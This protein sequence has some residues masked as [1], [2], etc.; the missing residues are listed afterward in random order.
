MLLSFF[1]VFV[2]GQRRKNKLNKAFVMYMLT[3]A[4]WLLMYMF[5][6][7]PL[8]EYT[9]MPLVKILL[10]FWLGTSFFYLRFI[11]IF[12]K[13]PFDVGYWWH[14]VTIGIGIL[15]GIFTSLVG[16]GYQS[17]PWGTMYTKGP[18]MGVVYLFCFV[19]PVLHASV[20]GV[21]IVQKTSDIILKK[22]MLLVAM[23]SVLTLLSGVFLAIINLRVTMRFDLYPFFPLTTIIQAGFIFWA[24]ARHNF[25]TFDTAQLEQL[26]DPMFED[27]PEGIVIAGEEGK[28]LRMN[29][30]ARNFLGVAGNSLSLPH[31]INELFASQQQAMWHNPYITV[32]TDIGERILLTSVSVLKSEDVSHGGKILF[33]HD[34]TELYNAERQLQ[35]AKE[36]LELRVQERTIDLL[37]VNANLSNEIKERLSIEKLMRASLGEKEMLLKE[38]HHRV[39]NNLQIVS[40]LLNLQSRQIRD[41]HDRALFIESQNRIR[42]IA[43]IHEKLYRSDTMAKVNMKPYISDLVAKLRQ[44]YI[45]ETGGVSIS[46]ELADASLSIDIAIPCGLIINELISNAFKYAFP[47]D[48]SGVVAVCFMVNAQ[49]CYTL[50]VEDNGCGLPPGIDLAHTNTLGLELVETLVGQIDGTMQMLPK[51]G[52]SVEI[53]FSEMP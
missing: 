5:F 44:S 35:N 52:L 32:A 36:E 2:V 10:L 47:D 49:N 48:A 42:S 25:L 13:R 9:K 12:S 20:M 31:T 24:M 27:S 39:K 34:A 23:G 4:L 17:M 46:L 50:I 38:V 29:T 11:Y 26:F 3:Y 6:W 15:L 8:P 41:P 19:F 45:Q 7:L 18:L 33:F 1:L 21:R 43:L 37:S 30:A 16:A 53:C 40:S 14:A 51:Q 28:I 22:Q